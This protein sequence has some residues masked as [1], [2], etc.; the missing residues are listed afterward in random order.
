[1]ASTRESIRLRKKTAYAVDRISDAGMAVGPNLAGLL[2]QLFRT[3]FHATTQPEFQQMLFDLVLQRC[4]CVNVE[5]QVW[6]DI[7]KSSQ[8]PVLD[9]R[10]LECIAK[11]LR[12]QIKPD[13]L[14]CLNRLI[15]DKNKM[16]EVCLPLNPNLSAG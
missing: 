9:G 2:N 16:Q 12:R 5:V 15:T 3:A 1:M 10:A 7:L 6:I 13:H 14:D 4:D 8:Q 11:C